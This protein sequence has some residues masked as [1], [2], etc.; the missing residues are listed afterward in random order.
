MLVLHGFS[1]SNYYNVA[2]LALLEKGLS[3]QEQVVYSGAGERYRPEYLLQ[4]PLG[5]VPCLQTEHG[6]LSESRCIVDY[7]E[8][9]YPER[10]LYPRGAFEIAKLLELTQVIDLYLELT[11]RRVLPNYFA[12]KPVPESIANDVRAT[13][14]KGAKALK[15]LARFDAYLLGEQFTAA[16]IAA[17]M[18]LPLVRTLSTQVLSCDPLAE[19]PGLLAYLERMEQRPNVQRIRADQAED[20]PKFLAHLKQL[21][22]I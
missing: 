3:F 11:A 6:F 9:A 8:R 15:Q 18:H 4:S 12:R 17:T 2:K 19:V 22:G 16:D 7:L 21:H 10:P 14:N 13:L 5:K 1:S 20:R